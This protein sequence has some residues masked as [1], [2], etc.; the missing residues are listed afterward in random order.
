MIEIWNSACPANPAIG[1]KPL[2]LLGEWFCTS[3]AKH[4]EYGHRYGVIAS[5]H[6][7]ADNMIRILAWYC[8]SLMG[9]FCSTILVVLVYTAICNS[10]FLVADAIHEGIVSKSAII[11][12]VVLY[13]HIMSFCICLKSKL[14]LESF[15]T[16]L[17]LL[18]VDK[19]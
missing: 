3:F 18:H 1:I 6:L 14:G 9:F 19:G 13:C 17:L 4:M 5:S 7:F 16:G 10:L 2:Q 11:W 15:F 8:R 12:M